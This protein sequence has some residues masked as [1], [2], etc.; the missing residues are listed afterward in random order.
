MLYLRSLAFNLVWYINLIVQMVVQTPYY[1]LTTKE[2]AKWVVRRWA[3]SCHWFQRILA[4]TKV[5]ISGLENVPEGGCIIASKHQSIWEFYAL[6]A[7]LENPA[8]VLKAELMKIPLFGWYVAKADQIPIRRGDRSKAMRA[9]L[10]KAEKAVAAGRQILIFPEGTRKAP[11][12]E[13]DYRYGVV[14]MYEQLKV[15]VVP[16]ALDSGLFWPRRQFLRHPGTLRA[17][18]L[19]PI[20]PGL[21]PKQFAAELERRIE[22]GCED[23]YAKTAMD[24][25]VPPLSQPV[26]DA[27]ERAKKRQAS[28]N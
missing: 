22:E 12:A 28:K 13:T 4:G 2:K 16:V 11:G 17:E 1:F 9:M 3:W 15:P 8:F 6:Y 7:E 20:Q 18:F 25:V 27:I 21:P 24:P 23:L 19:D 14:R 5:E 26:L 10:E